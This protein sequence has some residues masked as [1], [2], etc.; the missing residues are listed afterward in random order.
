MSYEDGW[1]ALRLEM[2]S[3]VPRTEYSLNYHHALLS[4]ITG[5]EVG[6]DSPPELQGRALRQAM[7]AWGFDFQWNTLV[8]GQYYNGIGTR[9]GHAAYANDGSDYD[10]DVRSTFSGD[11]E[12]VY[13][14]RPME[15]F[16]CPPHGELVETFSKA[17]ERA[18]GWYPEAVNMTGTY[19]SVMSG[20][21]AL[22]GWELLLT[23]AGE[24]PVRFGELTDRY[25]AWMQRFFYAIADS[26]AECVMIHD[27]FVWNSGG[28]MHP[29]W[30]RRYVFPNIA[31]Y[32]APLREAGKVVM[33][34][35][36]GDYTRYID[37]L[38]K[39]GISGFALEP[40]VDMAR[41]AERYGS[42]H[43]FIGNADT[44]VL[45][46]GSREDIRG[47]VARCMAIG[48]GCPGYFLSVGNHISPN[49]PVESAL[50]YNEAYESMCRR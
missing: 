34:T 44:R 7:L 16:K 14:L 3:R 12:E 2:P 45:M 36:D 22:F 46:F 31:R 38:A 42:T 33:F 1:A 5:I 20:L 29:D 18:C 41:I 37:D 40:T 49:T 23:A 6:P 43:A 19:T 30:Y 25:A 27:D 15:A 17:Y 4:A 10:D 28:F 21:I 26:S 50:Y 11:P 24:D 8:G 32:V 9:M 47:E 48:K 35:A 13:A 39:T